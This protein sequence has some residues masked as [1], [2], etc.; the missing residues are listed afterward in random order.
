M[1]DGA[2]SVLSRG[3]G[4]ET[5]AAAAAAA[6]GAGTAAKAIVAVCIGGSVA[7]GVCVER[8]VV[9]LSGADASEAVERPATQDV[10]EQP[11]PETPPPGTN[12]AAGSEPVTDP[13]EPSAPTPK[14]Q[15]ARATGFE[16][17]EPPTSQPASS[18]D[19][20]APASGGGGSGASGGGGGS[21]GFGIE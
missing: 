1:R 13:A 9:D 6:G 10:A 18:G 3:G 5:E 2:Q 8:G 21:G 15:V 17:S 7:A 16:R 4:H 20:G 11:V 19:F 14:E 12:D